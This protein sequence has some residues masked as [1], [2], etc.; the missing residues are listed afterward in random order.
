[1]TCTSLKEFL[2]EGNGRTLNISN[3]HNNKGSIFYAR[4]G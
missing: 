4:Y 1:M 3:R 2:E